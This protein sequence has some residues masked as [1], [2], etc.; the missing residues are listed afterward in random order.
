MNG[1]TSVACPMCMGDGLPAFVKAGYPHYRCSRCG[2]LFVFPTPTHEELA[3]YY[4]DAAR[5][6]VSQLCWQGSSRH[7]HHA[8]AWAA[9]RAEELAG[10]G[11][12]LDVGCGAGQFL[13]FVHT[14]GWQ[15]LAGVELSPAAAGIARK[16]SQARISCADFSD[17]KLEPGSL[18][19]ITMWDVFEHLREPR[20]LLCRCVKLLRPGGVL[21]VSTPNARGLTLR[22]RGEHSFLVVP[23]EHLVIATIRGLNAAAESAGLAVRHLRTVD[24]NLRDWVALFRGASGGDDGVGPVERATHART[25]ASLTTSR[26]FG[27]MQS[28]A[29]VALG[30]TRLG[31]QILAVAQRAR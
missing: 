21:I 7:A 26:A 16:A 8:W 23:P 1:S 24:L 15:D 11:P 5:Q 12:L 18:A 14:L 19:A 10:L 17:V 20:D 27:V 22:T 6:Q 29:N 31:D 3:A 9:R 2:S 4:V 25:Y 28:V 30:A 13:S